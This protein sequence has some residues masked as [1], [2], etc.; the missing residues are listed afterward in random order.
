MPSRARSSPAAR[1]PHRGAP[2]GPGSYVASDIIAMIDATRDV[3][4][5][6]DGQMARLRPDGIEYYDEAGNPIKPDVPMSVRIIG[7]AERR[8][9]DFC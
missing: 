3:V 8:L 9:P 2:A 6:A 1:I 5:L 7:V 4:V